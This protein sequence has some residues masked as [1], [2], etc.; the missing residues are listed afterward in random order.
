MSRDAEISNSTHDVHLPKFENPPVKET[1]LGVQFEVLSSFSTVHLGLYW[2]SLDKDW[3][4]VEDALPIEPVTESLD[5]DWSSGIGRSVNLQL[6]STPSIRLRITNPTRRRM[7]QVQN[8][9]FH[10][11]WLGPKGGRYPS[12]D[13]LRREFD[14]EFERFI[15]FIDENRLGE[16]KPNQWEVT[17]VNYIA[18]NTVWKTPE[19]WSGL[20]R[21]LHMPKDSLTCG[22]LESLSGQWHYQIEPQKGRL[23]VQLQHGVKELQEGGPSEEMVIMTLTAR[24]PAAS[25][26]ARSASESWQDGLDTG[27]RAIVNSFVE[28]TSQSAHEHWGIFYENDG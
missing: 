24:G 20:F 9:R 21:S 13:V 12:Y 7:I 3:S 23:H 1:V 6:V 19:D 4:I 28:L 16:V 8:N 15:L 27:R 10:C 26:V 2:N 14:T 17:Y 25:D 22:A 11:N 18:K 5:Q